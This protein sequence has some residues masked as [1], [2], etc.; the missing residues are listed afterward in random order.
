MTAEDYSLSANIKN[1]AQTFLKTITDLALLAS[2]EARLAGESIIKIIQL[3][4]IIKILAIITWLSLCGAVAFYVVSLNFSWIVAF[5]A[6]AGLN[7]IALVLAYLMQLKLKKNLYF[8]ATRRQ[9]R[10][11]VGKDTSHAQSEMESK[12]S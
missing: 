5:L 9:L 8:P 4:V 7:L 12:A 11:S 1:I 2:T 10:S 6:V 3:I